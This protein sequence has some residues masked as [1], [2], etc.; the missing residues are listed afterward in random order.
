MNKTKLEPFYLGI[1]AQYLDSIYTLERF[2]SVSRN[3]NIAINQMNI[4]P[5][6]GISSLQTA[7]TNISPLIHKIESK[8]FPHVDTFQVHF[9]YVEQ[10]SPDEL[11]KHPLIDVYKYVMKNN[12]NECQLLLQNR[13]KIRSIGIDTSYLVNF[14][15]ETMKSLR[16]LHVRITNANNTIIIN[17]II[18]AIKYNHSI[19]KVFIECDS[20]FIPRVITDILP[21]QSEHKNI[22]CII[23][24]FGDDDIE[25]IKQLIKKSKNIV[26][27]QDNGL[28]VFDEMF[29]NYSS[30]VILPRVQKTLRI[31]KQFKD[32]PKYQELKKLYFPFKE[33]TF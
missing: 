4:N 24:R 25:L 11:D 3:V 20:L 27:I 17:D 31:S 30:L 29:L 1:V 19:K 15:L 32:H 23:T 26:G 5:L 10:L 9:R 2:H 13:D 21:Y 16:Y 6:C 12:P 7:L 18:Q 14:T 22:V 33:E 28:K 8:V